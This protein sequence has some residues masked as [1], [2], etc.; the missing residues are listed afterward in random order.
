MNPGTTTRS[1]ASIVCV[2]VI[3]FFVITAMRPSLIPTLAT[4]SY[5]D[6][7]SMTRPLLMTRS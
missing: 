5:I 2:P 4:P 7:G 6:S 1:V 3:A